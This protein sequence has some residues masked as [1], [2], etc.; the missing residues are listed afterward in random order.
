[1]EHGY[2]GFTPQ[3]TH[4]HT[5]PPRLSRHDERNMKMLHSR[6]H[7]HTHI[8]SKKLM[9]I[10]KD[11]RLPL[12]N[13]TLLNDSACQQKPQ[14]INNTLVNADWLHS[15]GHKWSITHWGMLIGWLRQV[16]TN[17]SHVV[18]CW[19]AG[20]WRSPQTHFASFNVDSLI[21]IVIV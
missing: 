14:L 4:T 8:R 16:T 1:M 21:T 3:N 11:H 18:Q 12:T 20:Q 17:K 13:N 6:G 5:H 9:N 10:L 19:L 2:E 7:S 15:P